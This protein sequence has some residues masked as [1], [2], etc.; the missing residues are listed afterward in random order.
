MAGTTQMKRSHVCGELRRSDA[1]REVT[2][3]GWVSSQRDHGGL[4]FIDLRDRWGITQ[5]VF[6][7]EISKSVIETAKRLRM[8][9]V[10]VVRGKVV[11]R[12]GK[13]VNKDLAT[14]E[15]E[16]VVTELNVLNESKPV[17][18]AVKDPCE[19]MDETRLKYRY[20]DLR[21]PSM[22]NNLI[23]RHRT[24]QCVRSYFDNA[25][26]IEVETPFLMKSTPEGARD[27]LV[28]SRIHK[29]KFYALPQS[30]QQYKQLLMVSGY[31]RYF[32]I[33]KCFRDED[34]RADR[35]PEFTQI[36]V[37]MSFVDED[38][39]IGVMEKLMVRIFKD[40]LNIELKIPFPRLNYAEALARYGN[41]RPDLRFDMPIS[42][43]TELAGTTGFRVFQDTVLSQGR[44]RGLCLKKRG[45]MSRKQ[46]DELTD[47]A[48]SF[49][50]KGLVV[51][52]VTDEGIQSPVSKF[53]S[54]EEMQRIL[55]PFDAQVNDIV[56]LVADSESVCCEA[57]GNLRNYLARMFGMTDNVPFAPLWVLDFPLLEFDPEEKRFV[58]MHHPFT[59][60]KPEDV[61]LMDQ[62]PAN[63][64][65]RAYDL[66]LNGSEIAG[67]SIRIHRSDM[68]SKMFRLLGIDEE[69]AARKFGF[70]I[71][72]LDY[73][74]PPHGGIAFGFDRLVM[75]LAGESSI[76]EVIAF[77]KTT[78][79]LSLMD[80]CPS[81]VDAGQLRDLGLK[82][83]G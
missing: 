82:L 56:F 4:I 52:Q 19:A 5:I 15:I 8:E 53:I 39:V 73:G 24:A 34:L 75:M 14:G 48:K 21:R 31:D 25:G 55:K 49:G 59:S 35:Q 20:L 60:P 58:A 47:Y 74:A 41:D 17:P 81:E 36:D 23:L 65:A 63:V 54:D 3:T 68:Q 83:I 69:T 46:V 78:S 37:E 13:M 6:D 32:Q 57:L 11:A 1:D 70:L 72:A 33:V 16:V 30:P 61:S 10:I 66:V 2:L 80:G 62:D 45:R 64:R 76:R 42:D 77:P 38:D 26:F 12:P 18:L 43:I 40:I 7:P 44:V 51:I 29:G 9:T 67:G 50:A 28:P 22:Q 27:Y 71:E 79:A